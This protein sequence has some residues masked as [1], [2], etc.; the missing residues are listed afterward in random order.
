MNT[1]SGELAAAISRQPRDTPSGAACAFNA[2][3]PLGKPENNA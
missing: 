1:P 2:D 3:W